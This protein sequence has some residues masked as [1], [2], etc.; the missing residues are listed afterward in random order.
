MR[1][2]QLTGAPIGIGQ[3]N[4]VSGGV[5]RASFECSGGIRSKYAQSEISIKLFFRYE[6][7]LS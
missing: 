6:N 3:V 4:V 5:G 1:K 2:R 7:Y